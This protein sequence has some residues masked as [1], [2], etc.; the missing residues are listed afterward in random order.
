MSNDDDWGDT[1]DDFDA[2]DWEKVCAVE[3]DEEINEAYLFD[4]AEFDPDPASAAASEGEVRRS[5]EKTCLLQAEAERQWQA[6]QEANRAIRAQQS[7]G[8]DTLH[9][10]REIDEIY[11]ASERLD[12]ALRD[13]DYTALAKTDRHAI[14]R[15]LL[16]SAAYRGNGDLC[17]ALLDAGADVLYVSDADYRDYHEYGMPLYDAR[18]RAKISNDA[19]TIRVINRAW[20]AQEWAS[21]KC[22]GEQEQY[23]L[24]SLLCDAAAWGLTSVCVDMVGKGVEMNHT[25]LLEGRHP[26]ADAL[27]NGH[28]QT[29]LV[30]LA[31]GADLAALED[32]RSCAPADL[33]DAFRTAHRYLADEATAVAAVARQEAA[34]T[35]NRKA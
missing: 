3:R 26:L 28:F 33:C 20:V 2:Q 22:S 24:S 10:L 6:M 11:E 31:L 14:D 5:E 19:K 9:S 27:S 8:G 15:N 32:C 21:C 23:F 25:L 29:A 1:R 30:L 18:L 13:D 35:A 7:V 16:L 17:A 34:E 4:M 12:Q